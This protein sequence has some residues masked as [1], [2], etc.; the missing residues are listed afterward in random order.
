MAAE[1]YSSAI[2]LVHDLTDYMELGGRIDDF[3]ELKDAI[4]HYQDELVG[5]QSF[6]DSLNCT[7]YDYLMDLVPEDLLREVKLKL[8][9]ED[10]L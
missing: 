1:S 7:G 4:T 9:C 8:F 5:L 6:H 2:S 10:L 3:E